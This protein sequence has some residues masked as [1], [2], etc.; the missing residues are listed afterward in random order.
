MKTITP[1]EERD[2]ERE[3]VERSVTN[4][5]QNFQQHVRL[6]GETVRR[7]RQRHEAPEVSEGSSVPP[8]P[9]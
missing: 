2:A 5:A 6:F 7:R 8:S 9:R 1:Q 4:A 3:R